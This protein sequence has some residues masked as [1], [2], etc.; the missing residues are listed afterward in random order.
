MGFGAEAQENFEFCHLETPKS[1]NLTLFQRPP[2]C[3][4]DKQKGHWNM[5]TGGYE[6]LD[7]QA[8]GGVLLYG[9]NVVKYSSKT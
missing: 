6:R 2:L 9:Q 5:A 3:V 8:G 4:P 1:F 7:H